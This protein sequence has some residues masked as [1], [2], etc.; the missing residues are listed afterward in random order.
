M[1]G[2][3]SSG[4]SGSNGTR[5]EGGGGSSGYTRTYHSSSGGE[6]QTQNSRIDKSRASKNERAKYDKEHGI[7]VKLAD[8]GHTVMHLDDTTLTDGSYDALVDGVKTDFKQT[9]SANNIANY[10]THAIRNQGAE[11][12]VFNFTKM[13]AEIRKE[14][15][16]LTQRGIHGY[17]YEPG[18]RNHTRF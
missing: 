18:K 2:R 8:D 16:K 3:G 4:G 14:I 11:Q 9:S 1:G 17:Y 13:N 10:A 5:H 12:I 7:A 15:G 6:V